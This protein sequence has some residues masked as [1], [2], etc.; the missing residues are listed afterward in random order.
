MEQLL[1]VNPIGKRSKKMA[2]RRKHSRGRRGRRSY[3]NPI[4]L[5]TDS[6]LAS[7]LPGIAGGAAVYMIP[8]LL[9]LD[10]KYKVIFGL[11]F[12]L[13][14]GGLIKSLIGQKAAASFVTGAGT[15]TGVMGLDQL[16]K[17]NNIEVLKF[18]LGAELSA[19]DVQAIKML[20]AG[21]TSDNAI[22]QLLSAD[23]GEYTEISAE[24][25][26]LI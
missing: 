1:F 3:R 8:K 25:Q 12:T 24:Y 5:K 9:K 23:S 11:A 13:L 4:T 21:E 20:E 16:G 6:T 17:K 22:E 10:P 7:V 26:D 14:G 15:I 18:D 2:K 19:E